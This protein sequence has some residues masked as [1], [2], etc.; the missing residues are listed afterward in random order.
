MHHQ[1]MTSVWIKKLKTSLGCGQKIPRR[2]LSLKVLIEWSTCLPP[3]RSCQNRLFLQAPKARQLW[4]HLLS[5]LL[6]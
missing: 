2:L 4:R 3:D 6:I 1:R 5:R